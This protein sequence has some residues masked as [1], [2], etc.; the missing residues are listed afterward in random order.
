LVPVSMVV[1]GAVVQVSLDGML[2]IAGAGMA[3]VS[4]VALL[5]PAVRRL[6][7]EPPYEP[8]AQPDVAAA[9]A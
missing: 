2:V 9:A 1:A 3:I 7:F 8:E 4:V 5:S 6:G